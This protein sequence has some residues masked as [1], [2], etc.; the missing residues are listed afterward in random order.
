MMVF[1][2]ERCSL[3][4]NIPIRFFGGADLRG[5]TGMLGK[6]RN[7]GQ[8]AIKNTIETQRTKNTSTMFLFR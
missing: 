7:E 8:R 1:L 4:A 6:H 2:Q 5:W 3:F